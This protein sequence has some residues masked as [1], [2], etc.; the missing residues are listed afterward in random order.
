M[1]EIVRQYAKIIN[2]KTHELMIGAG[3]PIS[4]YIEIGMEWMET[5]KNWNNKWYEKGYLPNDE[6]IQPVPT[7]DEVKQKRSELYQLKV[8]PI[9]SHIQRLR[10]QTQTPEIETE[11]RKLQNERDYMVIKIKEEN[12]YPEEV[13]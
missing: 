7:Y 9:T 6:P 3:C 10:D 8:D 4:Y 2:P 11:I 13:K 5:E 12:P 1:G